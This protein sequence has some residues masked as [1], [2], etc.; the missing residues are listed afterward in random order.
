[1]TRGDDS[2]L[3]RLNVATFALSDLSDLLDLLD[4]SDLLGLLLCSN[5][6]D[7]LS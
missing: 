1:M 2:T 7:V 3:E 6:V 4:L 5:Y